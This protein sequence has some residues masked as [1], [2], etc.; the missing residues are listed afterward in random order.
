M[1]FILRHLFPL[2]LAWVLI[3]CAVYV[4][5]PIYRQRLRHPK[6]HPKRL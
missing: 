4:F 5:Q 1:E 2:I 6:I 3:V